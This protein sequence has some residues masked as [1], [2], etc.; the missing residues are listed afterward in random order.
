MPV[1]YQRFLS[2]NVVEGA[3]VFDEIK[4]QKKKVKIQ[5]YEINSKNNLV[6]PRPKLFKN[7]IKI[8]FLG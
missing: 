6:L 1:D 4:N 8:V 7:E 2:Q 3:R 5:W